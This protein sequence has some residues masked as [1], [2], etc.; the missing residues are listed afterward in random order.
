[1]ELAGGG[2]VVDGWSAIPPLNARLCRGIMSI[3][4]LR[5][6]S[7]VRVFGI[8]GTMYMKIYDLGFMI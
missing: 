6:M 3:A 2:G 1:M 5:A 7:I 8:C 4:L